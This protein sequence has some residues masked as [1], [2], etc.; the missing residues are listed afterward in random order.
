MF[1]GFAEFAFLHAKRLPRVD[2]RGGKPP[3]PSML[4]N[5]CIHSHH[6]ALALHPESRLITPA[7][8]KGDDVLNDVARMERVAASKQSPFGADVYGASET[9]N[10][11]LP[12]LDKERRKAQLETGLAAAVNGDF[13]FIRVEH[14]LPPWT[15]QSHDT[16]CD[17]DSD[18]GYRRS[19][20]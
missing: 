8:L 13:G 6:P 17:K 9:S 2:R 12:N 16:L 5:N 20:G 18:N 14:V 15:W 4:I 1:S 11:L 10:I 7:I 19:I 3:L